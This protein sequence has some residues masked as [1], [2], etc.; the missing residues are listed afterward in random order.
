[1]KKSIFKMDVKKLNARPSLK[2]IK[3]NKK[4]GN[5]EI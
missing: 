1:M 5:Y 2:T 3:K 4:E